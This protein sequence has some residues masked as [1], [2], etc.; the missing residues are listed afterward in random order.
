MS[1]HPKA[2]ASRKAAQLDEEFGEPKPGS[3]ISPEAAEFD[4]VRVV[5][6]TFGS[7]GDIWPIIG[8]GLALERRKA[9]VVILAHEPFRATIEAAGL[10]VVSHGTSAPP[11]P[12]AR[13]ITRHQQ[14]WMLSHILFHE[15]SSCFESL[16]KTVAQSSEP[17]VLVGTSAALWVRCLQELTGLPTVMVHFSPALFRSSHDVARRA[18]PLPFWLTQLGMRLLWWLKDMLLLYPM[19]ARPLNRFR[20]KLGLSPVFRPMHHWRNGG[21][22]TLGLFPDWFAGNP[23]ERPG[24]VFTGFPRFELEQ[25]DHQMP[26]GLEEFLASGP[27]PVIFT[28]GTAMA[29]RRR[30]Y[31]MAAAAC[32]RLGCR[33]V[34]ITRN[35]Q[36]LPSREVPGVFYTS[37]APFA[38]LFPRARLVAHHGGMGTTWQALA[39]GK[40]QLIIPF[41]HDQF[42][43]AARIRR[44]EVG[45]AVR[46]SQITLASLCDGLEAVAGPSFQLRAQQ[47]A[48]RMEPARVAL[49]RAA[50]L[51]LGL[52]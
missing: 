9:R 6:S 1:T 17:T 24:H 45:L 12:S 28:F 5:I 11:I 29:Q 46:A 3:R 25:A 44:L 47:L 19:M 38:Q 15:F 31:E 30:Y 4:P 7:L 36:N 21:N 14:A 34:L 22:L 33:G 48:T 42:D 39:A 37:S 18:K 23:P 51:I 52:N 27:P 20:R 2:R 40:P 49:D 8:L 41:A 10:T 13:V 35:A 50:E 32:W 43:N 16:R 26:S